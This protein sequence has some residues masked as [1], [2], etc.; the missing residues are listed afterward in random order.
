VLLGLLPP[1]EGR[2]LLDGRP[3]G[4]DNGPRAAYVPQAVF[5]ADDTLAK[6]I[7]FAVDDGNIDVER[8]HRVIVAAQLAPL[9]AQWPDGL[10]TVLGERGA[11]LSGGE[12]QRVGI[13]RALYHQPEL[14]VLDEATSALDSVTESKVL[15][16][17][18]AMRITTVI[19]AHRLST[20]SRCHRLAFVAEGTIAA[21]GSFDDLMRTNTEFRRLVEAADI[22]ATER[23]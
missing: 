13:A 1:R 11:R 6:N 17:I 15:N 16:A 19:V 22:G 7:A 9:V 8:L 10:N 3:A 23:P 14:L 21:T 5:I 20:I 2:R 4:A 12:R 18:D